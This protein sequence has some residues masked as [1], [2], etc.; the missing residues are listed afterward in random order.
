LYATGGVAFS[1]E[2]DNRALGVGDRGGNGGDGGDGG[3][4]GPPDGGDGGEGGD[5]GPGSAGQQ[6]RLRGNEDDQT[7]W[8][9]GLGAETKI[10]TVSRPFSLR[11]TSIN[12]AARKVS[13][14]SRVFISLAGGP[15]PPISVALLAQDGSGYA[16]AGYILY[17]AVASVATTLLLPDD[18]NKDISARWGEKSAPDRYDLAPISSTADGQPLIFS[19]SKGTGRGSGIPRMGLVVNTQFFSVLTGANCAL[20]MQRVIR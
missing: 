2:N 13:L 11:L 15:A 7:G 4:G 20:P 10:A 16:V 8:V 19:Q 6:I 18:T 1:G 5:G 17:P 9:A 12:N 3:D 14:E